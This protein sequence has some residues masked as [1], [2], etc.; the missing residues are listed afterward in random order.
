MTKLNTKIKFTYK[1]YKSLPESETKRYELIEGELIMVPSPNEYHQRISGRLEFI[2]RAFV[3]GK[4]LGRV[5][6]APFDVVF[7]KEDV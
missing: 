3:E 7:S 6:D 4:N 2:L 1:D 5:Y